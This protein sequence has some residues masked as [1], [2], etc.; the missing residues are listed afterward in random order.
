MSSYRNKLIFLFFLC[1]AIT[2][3]LL[4]EGESGAVSTLEIFK[5]LRMPKVISC[6]VFGGLLSIA[7]FM[8]QLYFQN[9]LAGPDIL[10]ITS[11]SIFFVAIWSFFSINLSPL[12]VSLG[13][14]F[15]SLTGA[16]FVFTFLAFFLKRGH[17]K[18]SLL[19][20]G[21]LVASILNS[22][23][24]ILSN[25]A[26]NIALKNY[27]LWIQGSMRNV[28]YADLPY[29]LLIFFI[30][31]FGVWKERKKMS[32]YVLGENYS[33]TLGLD[34]N[35]FKWTLIILTSVIVSFVSVYCG[36]VAFVGLISPF[37][38]RELLKTSNASILI[39]ANLLLGTFFVLLAEM[40]MTIFPGHGLSL[41]TI[42]GII[43]MPLM[44]YFLVD[45]RIRI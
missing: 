26:E 32:L 6:I 43:G 36:P 24:T 20:L 42:L 33:K 7:G 14:K 11:G 38:S 37:V 19:I 25:N 28:F 2:L 30:L 34:V 8:M 27:L 21:V 13:I 15:F 12:I 39:I 23:S 17:S 40:V 4:F 9:P 44:I 35:R 10:G 5:E 3:Y 29:I 18:V 22:L 1:F 16:F 31:L 41:N 45:K